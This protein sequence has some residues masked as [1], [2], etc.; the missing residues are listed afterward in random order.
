MTSSFIGEHEAPYEECH[1]ISLFRLGKNNGAYWRFACNQ[2][3]AM[4]WLQAKNNLMYCIQ[5]L[6][7]H[8]VDFTLLK[9]LSPQ[10]KLSKYSC[11]L[12]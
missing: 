8:E 3:R 4:Y 2:R 1:F 9:M 12:Y 11:P 7:N 6:M 10:R 5:L